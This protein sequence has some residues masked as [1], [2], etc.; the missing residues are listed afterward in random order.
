[1]PFSITALLSADPALHLLFPSLLLRL[2]YPAAS[3][4]GAELRGAT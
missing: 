4:A 3:V 2:L 1:M